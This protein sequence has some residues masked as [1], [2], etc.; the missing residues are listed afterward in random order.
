M[1][2]AV[3]ESLSCNPFF[4]VN[5]PAS[6]FLLPSCLCIICVLT[7][8]KGPK[9]RIMANCL[10]VISNTT[11]HKTKYWS[12]GPTLYSG[13]LGSNLSCTLIRVMTL[14]KLHNFFAFHF[15]IWK[16]GII[17]IVPKSDSGEDIINITCP[18][19]RTEPGSQWV[20]IKLYYYVNDYKVTSNNDFSFFLQQHL[21]WLCWPLFL[22][23]FGF[24]LLSVK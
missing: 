5:P 23:M 6:S 3:P 7:H 19:F 11:Q 18:N 12:Y 9:R 2:L 20:S 13:C 4:Y 14:D 17:I 22:F 21:V 24:L 16:M 8:K 1:G 15:L 10:H